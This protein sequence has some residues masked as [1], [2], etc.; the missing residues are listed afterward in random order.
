MVIIIIFQ[1]FH[2]IYNIYKYSLSV[3]LLWR[4]Y[5]WWSF[6]NHEIF[7]YMLLMLLSFVSVALFC[8]YYNDD[9][10]CEWHYESCGKPCMKTCR[11]PSG[12][13]YNKIPPL[14]GTNDM[15]WLC[16][17]VEGYNYLGRADWP[18]TLFSSKAIVLTVVTLY[19]LS[20][21]RDCHVVRLDCPS[22]SILC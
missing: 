22:V 3:M 11:N 6:D 8:D 7:S 16:M 19:S 18:C 13:C 10:M 2:F 12:I 9:D 4:F 14:E 5:T 1:H 17:Y 21:L 15:M 20:P